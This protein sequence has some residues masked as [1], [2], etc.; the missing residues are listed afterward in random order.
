MNTILI[1]G[2]GGVG[3]VAAH[4]CAQLPEIFHEIHLASRT[5]SKC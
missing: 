4:K 3:S 2:A 1:V 5:L